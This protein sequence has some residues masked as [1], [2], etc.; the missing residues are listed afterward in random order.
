M[1]GGAARSF[2]TVS[3]SA[4]LRTGRLRERCCPGPHTDLTDQ[5]HPRGINAPIA[6]VPRAGQ[7]VPERAKA[8]SFFDRLDRDKVRPKPPRVL[9][10][11]QR[12]RDADDDEHQIV[13]TV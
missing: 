2:R 13:W 12:A 9:C 10:P 8:E 11:L 4:S 7:K 3:S 6:E 1:Q 5:Q